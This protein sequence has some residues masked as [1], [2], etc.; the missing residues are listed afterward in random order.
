MRYV[1]AEMVLPDDLVRN[2]QKYIQGKYLYIPS[3]PQT[4]KKWGE[5]SGSRVYI[6]NRNEDIRNKYESGYSIQNLAQEFFLS[7][8]SIRKIIYTK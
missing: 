2:I 5:D 6:Q 8:H 4:R 1:K 3:Q 7:I